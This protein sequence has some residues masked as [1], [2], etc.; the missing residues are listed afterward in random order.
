MICQELVD[1]I[2]PARRR[3]RAPDE[4]R[5]ERKPLLPQA[6][7]VRSAAT[8]ARSQSVCDGGDPLRFAHR[9]SVERAQRDRHLLELFGPSSLSGMDRARS[10]RQSMESRSRLTV[11]SLHRLGLAPDRRRAEQAP[12]GREKSGPIQPVAAGRNE[13]KRAEEVPGIPIE[14]A[15][16][17]ANR[18]DFKVTRATLESLVTERRLPTR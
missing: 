17:G 11:D 12:L 10:F 2:G 14:L 15:V 18:V 8:T 9:L 3:W 4:L 13:T 5:A 6:S 1:G 16:D 7:S